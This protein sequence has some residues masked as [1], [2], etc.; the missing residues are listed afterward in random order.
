MAQNAPKWIFVFQK[1]PGGDTPGPPASVGTQT[2]FK[3][4]P[5]QEILVTG[6]DTLPDIDFGMQEDDRDACLE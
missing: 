4:T 2:S 1:F 3:R 5:P 6:L